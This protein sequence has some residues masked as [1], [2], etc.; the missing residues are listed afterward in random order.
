MLP[1]VF[2]VDVLGQ[3]TD[4][5]YRLVGT[6]VVR[7]TKRDF[8]GHMLSAIRDIG[9]QSKLIGMY[10]RTVSEKAPVLERF[11]YVTRGGVEK[12]YDVVVTP[13]ARNGVHVDMLFGYALHGE[14]AVEAE[15]TEETASEG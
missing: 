10:E 14:D 1:F 6:D 12:F 3:G 9:S 2:L 15:E 11:P 8:T 13:L 7:N 4:F 5:R